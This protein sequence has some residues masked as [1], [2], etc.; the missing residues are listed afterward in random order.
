MSFLRQKAKSLEAML[1]LAN[2]EKER[3]AQEITTRNKVLMDMMLQLSSE[4]E[5]IQEQV[6]FG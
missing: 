2:N 1:D 6:L 5:R 4:R 3:Y